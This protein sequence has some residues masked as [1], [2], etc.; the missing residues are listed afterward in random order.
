MSTLKGKKLSFD[1]S[2]AAKILK[3][4]IPS[5]IVERTSRGIDRN[6]NKF[7]DYSDGYKRT[8]ARMGEGDSVDL[9]VTGG[10]LEDIKTLS[11]EIKNG[12]LIQKVGAGS[13]SSASTSPPPVTKTKSGSTKK[14]RPRR[15]QTGRHGPQHNL[16][17]RWMH[18]GANGPKR[19]WLG[20]TD[21][22]W[23]EVI[24]Q[25]KRSKLIRLK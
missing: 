21:S 19:E 2:D 25:I 16:L 7:A 10:F 11:M 20:I 13:K 3:G 23:R 17:G 9:R 1:L 4:L 5:M 22:E 18:E 6:G 8:L 14:E 24:E 12:V 15:V